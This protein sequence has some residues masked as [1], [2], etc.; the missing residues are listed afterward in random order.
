MRV[1]EQDR[2]VILLTTWK[3]NDSFVM[4]FSVGFSVSDGSPLS[5]RDKLFSK[6][7]QFCE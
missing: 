7:G 2:E 3:R 5:Y 1:L 4:G 6:M